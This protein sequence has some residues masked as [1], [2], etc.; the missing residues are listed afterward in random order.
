MESLPAPSRPTSTRSLGRSVARWGLVV[1]VGLSGALAIDLVR[2]ALATDRVQW[3]EVDQIELWAGAAVSQDADPSRATVA[4]VDPTPPGTEAQRPRL[5]RF[6]ADWCPP[7]ESMKTDVFSKTR[8][9]DAIH[10]RFD[11]FS[12]DLTQPNADQES[13]GARY[14]VNYLPTLLITDAEGREI[15]RLEAAAD[16]DAFLRWLDHGH[17]RWGDNRGVDGPAGEVTETPQPAARLL[18]P[19]SHHEPID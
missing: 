12:V 9:A 10:Q 5:L 7:C 8:V 17:A 15:A 2:Q 18:S 11:A 16:A 4:V 6:T 1:L 13:L 3:V 19:I 14:R